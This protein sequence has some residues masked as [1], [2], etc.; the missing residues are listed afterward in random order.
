MSM[1]RQPEEAGNA[2]VQS[3]RQRWRGYLAVG[4]VRWRVL[5]LVFLATTINYIDRAALGVLQPVLASS[6]HWSAQDYADI[7]FWFQLGYAVGFAGQGWFIDRIGVRR[8]L[9]LA[10]LLWSL[11]AAAH[12]LAAS[13]TGFMVCRF[14][15]GLT[16][17]ANYPACIKA[18][19]LWFPPG[20]R[21]L[22]TGLFNAGTNVGALLTPIL[23]PLILLFWGWQ[24]VFFSLGVLGLLWLL[25]W[26]RHYHDPAQHPAVSPAEL[27]HIQAQA[28]VP[29]QPIPYWRILRLRA[30]WAYALAFSLTAPVF[31]FYLYWLPPYLN[32]QYQLGISVVSMGLPL[33]VIYL[34][35]DLGSV[36]G[37]LL[38][39]WLIGRGMAHVQARLLAMALCAL[40]ILSI[41]FAASA[42]SLWLAVAAIALAVGA[43]QAW[44]AN[45]WSLVMDMAPREV[46]GSVF[47][48]GSMLGAIGG[49]FMTQVVGYV[50]TVTDNHYALLFSLI[51]CCYFAALLWLYWMAPRH[52]AVTAA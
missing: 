10:V 5:L 40:C 37:G 4:D 2:S 9:A 44:T 11:A 51:P 23:L 29:G 47:G 32:Q 7:H 3:L 35:A 19:R 13:A 14:F 21:A 41:V 34:V 16:E 17:A 8:A 36:G 25:P 50:L 12:G 48:F 43:H 28:D 33:V 22:A 26:W 20:E 1:P 18:T 45:I 6:Q 42:S 52:V 39:S 38:S 24:A 30:T 46:V 15:L 27:A 49:M 31:W